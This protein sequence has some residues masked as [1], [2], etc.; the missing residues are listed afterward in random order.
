M[1]ALQQKLATTE[2][3][4]RKFF[5]ESLEEE[6]R[7]ARLTAYDEIAISTPTERGVR[8]KFPD[9]VVVDPKAVTESHRQIVAE[10]GGIKA[11]AG[12]PRSRRRSSLTGC[13]V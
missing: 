2:K 8:S 13:R 5:V 12:R 7:P 10:R 4:Y 1:A 3:W 9:V 6:L 11:V